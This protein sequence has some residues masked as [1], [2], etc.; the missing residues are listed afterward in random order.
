MI[1]KDPFINRQIFLFL[2]IVSLGLFLIYS[3]SAFISS[4]L[5]ALVISILARPMMKYLTLK[6][7]WNISLAALCVMLLSV[8]TVVLPVFFVGILLADKVNNL[9]LNTDQIYNMLLEVDRYISSYT[10]FKLISEDTLE[11]MK[12][13]ASNLIPAFLNQTL[14][15][16]AVVVMMYFMLFYM[17]IYSIDPRNFLGKILPIS[18][19][20]IELFVEEMDKMVFSNVVLAP[21]L[22]LIQGVIS[23]MAFAFCQLPEPIFW[24]MMC[25]VFSFI[26]IVG[27]TIVWLPAS[28]YLYVMGLN[29]QAII[30]FCFGALI[31]TNV[32]NVFRFVLQKKFANI[33]PLVT[34]LGVI[35]GL[36]WF[37]LTG[38]IFGPL[39]I[40]YFVLLLKVYR[41]EFSSSS[42][43][44][45][46][47]LVKIPSS[48]VHETTDPKTPTA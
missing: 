20:S 1:K 4:F 6:R 30:L 23:G 29:T 36:K 10:G 12:E 33:H 28:I 24:G 43:E 8:F 31:I 39:L 18:R 14:N 26:P 42:E 9:I 25:A 3:L 46:E 11:K 41:S 35:V 34:I 22:A 17:L 48:E 13:I 38:L 2:I 32:D 37:G 44:K 40:S 16:I 7:K 27:T 47:I 15:M 5:V 45:T 19:Q 21:F